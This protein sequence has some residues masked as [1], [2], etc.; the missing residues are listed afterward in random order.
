M[1]AELD[2]VRDPNIVEACPECDA[3][4]IEFSSKGGIAYGDRPGAKRY[5]C[6]RC[7]HLFDET[8]KRERYAP[9]NTKGL[10]K[11]LLDADPDDVSAP[12]G[13]A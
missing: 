6:K 12:G 5:H 2:H 1:K 11:R 9:G 10:A 7:G 13:D 3:T 4:G 8:V